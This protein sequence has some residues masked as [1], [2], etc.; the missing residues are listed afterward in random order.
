MVDH[1]YVGLIYTDCYVVLYA[2]FLLYSQV[3]LVPIAHEDPII[4]PYVI[5][6]Q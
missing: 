3:Q 4:Q 1:L 6:S 2:V 5:L